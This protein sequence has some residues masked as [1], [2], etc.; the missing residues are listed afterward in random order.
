MYIKHPTL[1]VKIWVEDN[2]IVG[3]QLAEKAAFSEK[4]AKPAKTKSSKKSE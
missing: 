2:K 4:T 1:P 3:A